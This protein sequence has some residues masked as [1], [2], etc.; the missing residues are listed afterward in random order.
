MTRAGKRVGG[1]KTLFPEATHCFYA[2]YFPTDVYLVKFRL[3]TVLH[4]QESNQVQTGARTVPTSSELFQVLAENWKPHHF[5]AS[6]SS[7]CCIPLTT[8][9]P[10]WVLQF[11]ERMQFC[12]IFQRFFLCVCVWKIKVLHFGLTPFLLPRFLSL[13]P[14]PG[15]TRGRFPPTENR[16]TVFSCS[17]RNRSD[18][19]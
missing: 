4:T 11:G 18:C 16:M 2:W 10:V 17:N 15:D 1:K 19:G 14:M 8:G 12:R 6:S 13:W 5:S 9:H 7:A 3:N